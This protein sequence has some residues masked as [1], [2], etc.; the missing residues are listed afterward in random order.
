MKAKLH[1]F[2]YIIKPDTLSLTVELFEK[3]NCT[4]SYQEEK[5][6]WCM[7]EQKPLPVDIQ[8]IEF[9]SPEVSR[10]IK[11]STHICF[12]SD[13]PQ[14]DLDEIKKWAKKKS[15]RFEQGKWSDEMLWFDLPGIFGNFV[16]EIMHK[17][18]VNSKNISTRK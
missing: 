3:F 12:L 1:H 16:I 10:E 15:I 7:L 9:K 17:N 2:A 4:I 6:T 11:N 14:S 5:A 13:N 18:I 8:I